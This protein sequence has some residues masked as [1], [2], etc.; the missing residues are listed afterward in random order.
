MSYTL[1]SVTAVGDGYYR[2]SFT[3]CSKEFVVDIPKSRLDEV[4]AALSDLNFNEP[5]TIDIRRRQEFGNPCGNSDGYGIRFQCSEDWIT[6]VIPVKQSN[7]A[8]NNDN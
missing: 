1:K 8:V 4:F 3:P 5:F 7:N 2:F 6:G